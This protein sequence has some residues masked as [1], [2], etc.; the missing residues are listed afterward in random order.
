MSRRT[1]DGSRFGASRALSQN[2]RCGCQVPQKRAGNFLLH[3]GRL[4]SGCRFG[5][6]YHEQRVG[7]RIL[8]LAGAVHNL[9]VHPH[10]C[11]LSSIEIHAFSTTQLFQKVGQ[12]GQL[13]A[14]RQ[15]RLPA[16]H[17]QEIKNVSGSIRPPRGDDARTWNARAIL[18]MCR[19]ADSSLRM[20]ACH[21]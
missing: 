17:D 8:A 21:P 2:L 3:P 1:E 16:I 5:F 12:L 9:T 19:A 18:R 15:A 14:R 13:H 10:L 4:L 20:P 6:A 7:H 11:G